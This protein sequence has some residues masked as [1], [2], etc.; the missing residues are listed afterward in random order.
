M[1]TRGDVERLEKTI[2]QLNAL[3]RE[4][5]VLS[6]KSPNDASNL[7]KLQMIDGVLEVANNVL[8]EPY[9]PIEG[10]DKF[11]EDD[12]PS[13]SDVVFVLAQYV[14]EVDRFRTDNVVMHQGEWY[15][16]LDGKVSDLHADPKSRRVG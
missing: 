8:G 12:A 7:F 6:K 11:R 10:F 9:K 13:T 3:H 4:M 15:Y 2:G 1:K 14:E 16:V 5:S